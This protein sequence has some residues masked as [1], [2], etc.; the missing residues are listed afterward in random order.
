MRHN[1]ILEQGKG[2][3]AESQEKNFNVSWD[4][5]HRDTKALSW[6]LAEK[7]PWQRIVAIARGGLVPAAIVARELNIRLIDTVCIASYDH[8]D[9]GNITV[10]KQ[11]VGDGA[12]TLLVDDLVDTG[13]TARAVREMLPKAY[14]ATVYAKPEGASLVDTFLTE[15]SQDTWIHFPWDT[16]LH[17]SQPLAE[18][19]GE[20]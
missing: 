17:Y 10:L 16:E 2:A 14:F 9:Q 8:M 13:R 7:G 1:A 19:L 18:R 5:L 12:D 20:R 6:R 11:V 4:Q 3:M 15:V